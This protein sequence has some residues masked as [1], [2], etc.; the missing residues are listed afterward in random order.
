MKKILL[1]LSVLTTVSYAQTEFDA[2]RLIQ[3][4][5][6]GTARYTSMAGA[7]GALGGDPSAIKDNP[8]GLGIYRSSE[9]SVT[10]NSLNQ[11][12][13]ANWS[14]IISNA[15]LEKPGFT[16]VSYIVSFPTTRSGE[17]STGLKRSNFAINYN[18][19]KDFNR[20]IRINGVNNS[21]SSVTDYMAYFTGNI[22]GSS[23]YETNSY[24]PFNNTS[25][26]WISIL[27]GNAGLMNE[28]VDSGDGSTQY[29]QSLLNSGETVTPA[30]TLTEYGYFDEYAFSWSGNFNN[31][32]FIGATVNIHDISYRADSEYKEDFGGGGNMS[33][34]NVFKSTATGMNVNAGAIFIPLDF[35]RIGA[36]VKTPLIYTISDFHYADM[37]YYFD[38]SSNGTIKTPYGDNNY[39]FKT[40]LVY[41]LSASLIMGKR[42]VIGV[43]Y[44]TSNNYN[45]RFMDTNNDVAAFRYENDSIKALFNEQNTLKIGAEYKLGSKLAIRG[46]FATTGPL[47]SSTL[48]KEMMPNTL[49]TDLEYYV[50]KSTTYMTAGLGYRDT[51]WYFDLAYMN[52]ELNEEFYP[53]NSKNLSTNLAVKPASVYT[54]NASLVATVGFRF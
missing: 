40:P 14:D 20:E 27:A 12:T 52:K 6:T 44:I 41:S 8:A 18:R 16:N 32:L 2:L 26:P 29:W 22:S 43:E 30:Y 23:I 15:T 10:F 39:N 54:N 45:S 19:V 13:S 37:N 48:A 47:T 33:L 35:L 9:I 17:K 46:G 49:R 42:G 53:Y 5:I 51:H 28:F 1:I 24:D 34:F 3:P 36:S 25:V 4:D 21:T 31:R 38:A 50:H 7:F 11:S